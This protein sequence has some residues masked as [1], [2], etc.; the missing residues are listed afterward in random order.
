MANV[1]AKTERLFVANRGEIALRVIKAA[2]ELG[3]ETVLG[4]SIAD[5]DSPAAREAGQTVS[6]EGYVELTGYAAL[7]ASTPAGL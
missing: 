5:T 6:G 2:H 4:V 7:P 3:I 1:T